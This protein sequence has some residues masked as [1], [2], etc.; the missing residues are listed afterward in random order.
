L[1]EG[2]STC[3][4]FFSSIESD[5]I[6]GG[7]ATALGRGQPR[8]LTQSARR[9]R[10]CV[11]AI[12]GPCIN[13]STAN[14]LVLPETIADLR[15][16]LR[17]SFGCQQGGRRFTMT[18]ISKDA[19]GARHALY[20][21]LRVRLGKNPTPVPCTLS[22][23]PGRWQYAAPGL[24]RQ[25]RWFGGSSRRRRLR[26]SG[27]G[28]KNRSAVGFFGAGRPVYGVG[29]AGCVLLPPLVRGVARLF[30]AG[31]GLPVFWRP[32]GLAFGTRHT[33]GEEN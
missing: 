24:A 9:S 29:A 25:R 5:I 27:S 21:R 13:E 28:R 18:T 11:R 8:Y 12:G 20:Q 32:T 16:E 23:G 14:E 6:A 26:F 17:G 4:L 19:R 33:C 1:S 7:F 10:G 15:A 3:A 22:A 2:W 30:A 31:S